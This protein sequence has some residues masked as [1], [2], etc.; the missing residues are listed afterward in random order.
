MIQKY[1]EARAITS[2][3]FDDY[4]NVGFGKQGIY[5]LFI[6]FLLLKK[7]FFLCRI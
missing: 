2:T 3:N 5:A 7:S 6:Q 1:L 4:R